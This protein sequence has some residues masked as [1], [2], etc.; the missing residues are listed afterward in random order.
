MA[1]DYPPATGTTKIDNDRVRVTE[2]RFGPGQATGHHRHEFDYVV[3]PLTTGRLKIVDKDGAESFASLAEGE[4]YYRP[5]GV[6]HNV[7]NDDG[8]ENAFIEIEIR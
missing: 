6:E 2:W 7:I 8:R 1:Q 4:P 5:A 3:V